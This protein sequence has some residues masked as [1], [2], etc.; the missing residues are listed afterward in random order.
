M[1]LQG[2]VLWKAPPLKCTARKRLRLISVEMYSKSVRSMVSNKTKAG[3]LVS[4]NQPRGGSGNGKRPREEL[5]SWTNRLSV[6]RSWS[7]ACQQAIMSHRCVDNDAT[8]WL[9]HEMWLV[10]SDENTG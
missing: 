8:E 1:Q 6:W 5:L 7:I 9:C 10:S 2:R 3:E 4:N